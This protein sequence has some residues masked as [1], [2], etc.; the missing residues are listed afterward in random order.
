VDDHINIA[1]GP[2]AENVIDIS[3]ND[4]WVNQTAKTLAGPNNPPYKPGNPPPADGAV[5]IPIDI[6]LSCSDGDPRHW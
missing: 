4:T 6:D 5:N 2:D 1:V 3:D